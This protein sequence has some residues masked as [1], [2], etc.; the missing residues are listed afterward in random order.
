MF[1]HYI[2]SPH[3]LQLCITI[4]I[5]KRLQIGR[6]LFARHKML[7]TGAAEYTIALIKEQKQQE[8]KKHRV[9]EDE[10]T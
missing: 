3:N 9:I 5:Q 7:S 8:K 10:E 2:F 1:L 4:I 6:N